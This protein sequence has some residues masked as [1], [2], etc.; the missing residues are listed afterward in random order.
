MVQ[1]WP[2]DR[3]SHISCLRERE[4]QVI[5][6]YYEE[7]LT[8][9]QIAGRLEVDESRVSQIHSAALARLRMSIGSLLH[10]RRA[11]STDAP[12]FTFQA[13]ESGTRHTPAN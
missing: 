1:K 5:T 9:K 4:Q 11:T 6:L 3:S 12:Q 10:P 8:M 2:N 13:K 7:E